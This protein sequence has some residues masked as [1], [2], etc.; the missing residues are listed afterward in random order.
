MD[1]FIFPGLHHV[2]ALMK[3]GLGVWDAARD[4]IFLSHPFLHLGATDG[5]GMTN[6]NGLTGHSGAFGCRLYCAVKGHRKEGGN[7]YYSALLKPN[8]YDVAGCNHDDVDGS[9]LPST[10]VFEYQTALRKVLTSQT[11]AQHE[12]N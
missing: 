10:N 1:S 3:E 9:H 4:L 6:L 11:T 12:D 7:H 2:A 8:D 5:P